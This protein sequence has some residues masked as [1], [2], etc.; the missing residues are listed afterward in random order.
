MRISDWRSYVCSSDLIV[1]QEAAADQRQGS[2]HG[3][4]LIAGARNLDMA[5]RD[6][7]RAAGEHG[8]SPRDDPTGRHLV[9]RQRAGLVRADHRSGAERFHRGE[10]ADRSEEHTSELQSLM[11]TSYAVFCL[12]KKNTQQA[13]TENKE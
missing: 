5:L 12:K 7:A 13:S 9:T 4:G 3:L 6:V 2:G 10:L 8:V 1:A 11:R